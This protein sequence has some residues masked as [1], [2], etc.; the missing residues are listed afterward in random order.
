MA[1]E[2]A[3]AKFGYGD[4]RS[5]FVDQCIE[6]GILILVLVAESIILWRIRKRP[7]RKVFAWGY[8]LSLSWV[9]VIL[10]FLNFAIY[11]H[12][13]SIVFRPNVK[14]YWSFIGIAHIFLAIMLVQACFRKKKF[15]P[16]DPSNILDDYADKFE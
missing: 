11:G 9:L 10:P 5:A 2:E 15:V 4:Y 6:V 14:L 3:K 8:I 7:F 1:M 12:I 13:L 16:T